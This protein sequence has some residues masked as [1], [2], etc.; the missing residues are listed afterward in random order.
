M[1]LEMTSEPMLLPYNRVHEAL[2]SHRMVQG[3]IVMEKNVYDT[4]LAMA[5]YIHL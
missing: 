4:V 3:Y 2:R 1:A 5:P